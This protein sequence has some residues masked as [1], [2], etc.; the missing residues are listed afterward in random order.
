MDTINVGRYRRSPTSRAA[1][2]DPV[3]Q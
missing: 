1:S 3:A 2:S